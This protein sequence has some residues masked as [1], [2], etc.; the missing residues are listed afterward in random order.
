MTLRTRLLTLIAIAGVAL[1][2]VAGFHLL[3]LGLLATDGS[4]ME[5]GISEGDL[6]VT[7][8]APQ[9]HHGDVVAYR[10][11]EIGRMVLHRV[12]DRDGDRFVTKGDNNSWLD[13]DEPTSAEISGELWLRVSRGGVAL[14]WLRSPMG[15]SAMAVVAGAAMLLTTTRSRRGEPKA[16]K[17]PESPGGHGGHGGHATPGAPGARRLRASSPEVASAATTVA[18]AAAGVLVVAVALS[19]VAHTRPLQTS[20]TVPAPFTHVA[21]VAYSAVADPTVYEAGTV[22]TGD[23]VFLRV[24]PQLDVHFS[25]A[26]DSDRQLPTEPQA[27]VALDLEIRGGSGWKR[28]QSLVERQTFAGG[29]AETTAQLDLPSIHRTAARVQAATGVVDPYTVA[30]VGHVEVRSR[31]DGA[32]VEETFEPE[33]EFRLDPSALVPVEKESLTPGEPIRVSQPSQATLSRSQPTRVEMG[34]IGIA[35]ST[36]RLLAVIAAGCAA[37]VGLVAL[38]VLVVSARARRRRPSEE[39]GHAGLP[40]GA[41]RVASLELPPNPTTVNTGTL[42]ALAEVAARHSLPLLV[43]EQPDE[44]IF[45]VVVQATVFYHRERTTSRGVARTVGGA[46]PGMSS[47][48]RGSAARVG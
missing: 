16:P 8:R 21:E 39:A 9:Y 29:K 44:R 45:V 17:A 2:S 25:Y 19:A 5:P 20:T 46:A 1:T 11:E 30:L 10:S 33:V 23:T 35:T 13:P 27:T 4:S 34:M 31:V 42:D 37:V 18:Q 40:A 48:G 15:L 14:G 41:L 32:A 38:A 24:V 36:A 47:A 7:R 22:T 6:V 28:T 43:K 26:L 3:G 12:V